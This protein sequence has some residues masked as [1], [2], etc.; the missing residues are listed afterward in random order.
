MPGQLLPLT[1]LGVSEE[2]TGARPL[3]VRQEP[4]FPAQAPPLQRGG[5]SPPTWPRIP[6]EGKG[7]ELRRHIPGLSA[8]IMTH[9]LSAGPSY[10]PGGYAPRLRTRESPEPQAL[11]DSRSQNSGPQGPRASPTCCSARRSRRGSRG[12]FQP[13]ATAPPARPPGAEAAV[14]RGGGGGDQALRRH[15]Y[16]GC[17]CCHYCC[18]ASQ[19][20]RGLSA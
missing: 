4:S 7:E 14:L 10:T 20:A 17:S 12:T 9:P 1:D 11:R 18:D 19:P 6:G 16:S 5:G 2:D 3:A 15:C 8:S 13:P